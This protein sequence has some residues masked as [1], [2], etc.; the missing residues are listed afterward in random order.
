MKEDLLPA[1]KKRKRQAMSATVLG[2]TVSLTRMDIAEVIGLP[3]SN[4]LIPLVAR[5]LLIDKRL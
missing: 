2:L 1:L 3:E 4:R 5:R